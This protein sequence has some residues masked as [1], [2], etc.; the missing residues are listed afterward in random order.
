MTGSPPN[1]VV[2]LCDTL[3]AKHMSV[4][5]Y[6]RDTTPRL[7]QLVKEAGFTV[8]KNCFAPASWT[9]PSHASL[10]TGLYPHEHGCDGSNLFL[11]TNIVTLPSVLK[12]MGYKTVG[13]TSNKLVS[14]F[15]GYARGFDEFHEMWN[16][17]DEDEKSRETFRRL[18]EVGKTGK[19]KIVAENIL[20]GEF[21]PTLKAVSNV[22]YA[23]KN[24][25]F[26]DSTFATLRSLALAK[27]TIDGHA[28]TKP[29]FLFIN[30][31]QA[32]DKYNPPKP[33]RNVFV[34]DNPA[35]EGK[36][37]H[38][39]DEFIHYAVKPF[40]KEFLDYTRGLYDEE[41]L[42]IDNVIAE[43]FDALRQKSISDE[44]VFIV[45]SDHGEMF[46]EH[47]HI[48]HGYSLNNEL[49]HVPLVVKWPSKIEV[50][51]GHEDRITQL[52]DLYPT[53]HDL[54]GAFYPTPDS[55]VSLLGENE[56]KY[57]IA[58]FADFA[59]KLPSFLKHKPDFKAEELIV[60]Q[61]AALIYK[62]EGK[63]YKLLKERGKEDELYDITMDFYEN[64]KLCEKDALEHANSVL[65][66][67]PEAG[68][69]AER[70]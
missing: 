12:G 8:Y 19:L 47:G 34:K 70:Y 43:I 3:G 32:H 36:H 14:R 17:H 69:F 33:F 40:D 42:Y 4:Y 50:G 38:E 56:R 41:T 64:A 67:L 11:D 37:Q 9:T 25:I 63:M 27:R 58:E 61:H 30:L 46:G 39:L 7:R 23:R 15:M 55:S 2:I 68:I 45:T 53:L 54:S 66:A 21:D 22:L 18:W 35:L 60:R 26:R 28:S 24:D 13:V 5:G 52:H 10:F 1:I 65:A 59:F 29:F 6:E 16:R 44:T 62:H 48:Q 51:S 20:K 57:A 31:M 49:I